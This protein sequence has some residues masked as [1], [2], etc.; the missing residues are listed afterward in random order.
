VEKYLP[1]VKRE[2]AA[3]MSA[4]LINQKDI[5]YLKQ[6]IKEI[7]AVNPVLA[8]WI[9]KFSKTTNDRKGSAFCAIILYKMLYSQ[10]EADLM[11]ADLA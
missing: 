3:S 10:I 5:K 9:K 4:N 8:D 7:E 1:V 6:Q 2:I 11:N